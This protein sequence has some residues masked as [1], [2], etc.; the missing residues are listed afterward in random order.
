MQSHATWSTTCMRYYRLVRH[1]ATME[2]VW[3][4]LQRVSRGKH[5]YVPHR[6]QWTHWHTLLMVANIFCYI[7]TISIFCGI[8]SYLNAWWTTFNHVKTSQTYVSWPCV[9][10]TTPNAYCINTSATCE[11]HT[12]SE[13]HGDD[14]SIIII[15]LH[16]AIWIKI[17]ANILITDYLWPIQANNWSDWMAVIAG[18]IAI[19]T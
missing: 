11:S 14:I 4:G 18:N 15:E 6:C 1:I 10:H 13:R 19:Q 7:T 9:T 8:H 16:H 12:V 2:A 5:D 17:L 3:S